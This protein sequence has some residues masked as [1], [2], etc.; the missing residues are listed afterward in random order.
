MK[1]W[2]LLILLVVGAALIV[3][4]LCYLRFWPATAPVGSGPAGPAVDRA[5]FA[6]TWT[7]RNVLL[8]GLGDSVTFGFGAADGYGYFARL[9]ANPDDEWPQMKGICLSAVL[10]GLETRNAAVSGTTS[11]QHLQFIKESLQ[12]QDPAVFGLI[13]ITTG[14][15]D[16]IHDYGRSPP[17][18]GAMYG[19]TI[20]EAKP[21]ISNFQLRLHE[22]IDLIEARF[23]GGRRIFLADVYDPT[24]GVGDA[25]N[26]GLPKW[27]DGLEIHA[28]Y[29]DVIHRCAAQRPSVHLV[30]MHDAFLGHG[31]HCTQSW[32]EHYRTED[33]YYW[34]AN[35]LEDP[36]QRGY[37]A[38]RRL[39]LIEIAE[40][41]DQWAAEDPSQPTPETANSP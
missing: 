16:L 25:Q 12:E 2:R 15:N 5:A 1:K 34:Y 40:T 36:N 37:D 35:N 33:P 27:P 23:P 31:I 13:V 17:R 32:G 14:G 4:V 29:N 41:A 6:K 22:M 3:G 30:P 20:A 24:D 39:F 26:A 11:I 8:L 7:T 19:A 38:I 10:P 18:E 28:A 21:W 9:A